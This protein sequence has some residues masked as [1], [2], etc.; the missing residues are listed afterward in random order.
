MPTLSK[1]T[2][3]FTLKE[4]QESRQWLMI[5]VAGKPLGR[6]CSQIALRL[7]GKHKP[8][9]QPHLDMGDNIVVLNAE[10][11]K[12]TGKKMDTKTAFSTTGAPGG[13]KFVAYNRV[14]QDKPEKI[15][16]LAVKGMLPHGSFGKRL[17]KKMHVYRG[18]EHP[19]KAQ[20][21]KEVK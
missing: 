16:E 19:H 1:Q 11:V 20:N 3:T 21:P 13:T 6:I 5:D 9:Y 7:K 15:I 2:R 18:A 8:S 17:M 14:I 4:S 10:K 12:L